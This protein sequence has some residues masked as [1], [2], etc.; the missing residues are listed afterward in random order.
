M[1]RQPAAGRDRGHDGRLFLLQDGDRDRGQ[2]VFVAWRHLFDGGIRDIAVAR[3]ADGG[4]TFSAPVRVSEDNWRIDACPDDG[5]AMAVDASGTLDIIWPTLVHDPGGDRIAIFESSSTDGGAA[6][7]RRRR[8]DTATASAAHP[9]IAVGTAGTAVVWD[10]L[11]NGER[12]SWMRIGGAEPV[13]VSVSTTAN[14]PAVAAT[15]RGFVAGW[16][17]QDGEHAILRT[18]VIHR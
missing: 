17:E 12:R 9:R 6:F 10:E 2:D 15:A 4:A 18:R 13:S 1:E 11:A 14:Y 5:P 16:T 8:I 7:A 3:S